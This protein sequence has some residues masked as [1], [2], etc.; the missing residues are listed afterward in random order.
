MCLRMDQL[1]YAVLDNGRIERNTGKMVTHPKAA[2]FANS[3]LLDG[4]HSFAELEVRIAQLKSTKQRGDAFEVFS[5]AYLATQGVMQAKEVWSFD[6]I[7]RDLMRRY[8]IETQVDNGIDGVYETTDGTHVAYRSK[9]RTGRPNLTWR[10]L[11]TF[12][13][14]SEQFNCRVTI[15]NSDSLAA[16]IWNRGEACFVF[17]VRTLSGSRQPTLM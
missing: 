4:L 16:S 8:G 5:E 3:G 17:E 12:V 10:E 13:G 6:A 14:L 7:P 11:S 9:F 2:H 1:P 15:T